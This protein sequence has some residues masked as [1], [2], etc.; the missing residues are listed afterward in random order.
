MSKMKQRMAFVMS[1]AMAFTSVDTGLLV[2]AEDVTTVAE[3]STV[4][5]QDAEK[6]AEEEDI[7]VADEDVEEE[8]VTDGEVAEQAFGEE[9][10]MVIEPQEVVEE[11]NEAIA[12][13]ADEGGS[14]VVDPKTWIDDK[15]A[16]W[17]EENKCYV[18]NNMVKK[19]NNCK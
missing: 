19:G 5:V 12:T 7:E 14:A 1:L 9:G 6:E 2:S 16:T 17:D 11:S 3:E 15:K 18:I 13:Y 10:A 4:E 8:I